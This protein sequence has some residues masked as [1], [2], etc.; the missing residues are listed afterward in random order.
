VRSMSQFLLHDALP[1]T[2]FPP[3]SI[4][5]WSTFQ[6]GLE[7]ANGALKRSFNAYR[8][9]IWIPS[10]SGGAVEVWG[11]LRSAP[12]GSTQH[13]QIQW[14][15]ATRAWQTIGNVVVSGPGE[16]FTVRVRPQSAG[17]L[18]IVWRGFHSRPVA[19]G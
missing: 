13:A 5:Y 12:H 11:M 7:F 19:V 14:S 6:T 3:G 8:I 9:P 2:K 10:G 1:D 16:T 15:G 17:R 4:G 18:R